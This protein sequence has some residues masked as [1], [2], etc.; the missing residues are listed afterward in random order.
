V[1]DTG[2]S[3]IPSPALE[4]RELNSLRLELMDDYGLE[5]LVYQPTSHDK[6][7]L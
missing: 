2:A 3:I 5:Q 1:A 4:L 7:T 6:E